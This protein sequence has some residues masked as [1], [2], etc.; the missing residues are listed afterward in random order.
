[1]KRTRSASVIAI[2]AFAAAGLG[3]GAAVAACGTTAQVA[4]A[5]GT[6]PGQATYSYYQSMM[7]R[8]YSG[9]SGSMMGGISRSSIMG[10]S[11]YRW[12]MGGL[13]SP[14]WMRGHALP[15]FMMGTSSARS[16]TAPR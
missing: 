5:A 1:M 7:R 14:A 10:P 9:A 2:A 16:M 12:M 6:T 11:G 4:T 3:A 8:L 13:N 15:G